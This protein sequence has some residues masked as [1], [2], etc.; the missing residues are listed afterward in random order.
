M[1]QAICPV[2]LFHPLKTSSERVRT[3]ARRCLLLALLISSSYS[4]AEQDNWADAEQAQSAAQLSAEQLR[5]V[6][7]P[8]RK[9]WNLTHYQLDF[10]VD[11]ENKSL[12]GTNVMSY[13]VLSETKAL[14][15][16][17]Q[18]PMVLESA[19]QN[20]EN[21]E[22]EKHGFSYLIS[23][24]Q[25][26]E[27]G[28]EYQ[29]TLAFSGQP[30]EAKNAPWDGGIV[31][32][33]DDNNMPFVA[34]ANQGI[35][36]S[37]W[38]PNKDH[39]YDEP[40]RGIDINIEVPEY[41]MAVANGRLIGV[42]DNLERGSKTYR[43]Q[44]KN[45]I[46][47]YGVNFNLGDYVQF[48]EQYQ[49]ESG[50]LSMD[51]YVLRDNE[52]IAKKQFKD[53]TRT[54]EAFEYWFGPY[55]FYQDGFK[56]VEVPYLGMEHQSSVTYGNGYQNGYKG[57][58][59]SDSGWGMLFDYIII[60]EMGHEWFA[61]NVTASDL[62]D[63]WIQE[64]FT[65][66]SEGL[67]VEY[68]YGKAAGAE[69]LR[70]LRRN[71]SNNKALVGKYNTNQWSTG[72][73]YPKGA[74]LLHTLRQLINNDEKWREILRGLGKAFYHKTVNTQQ[75]EQYISEQTGQDFSLIF[76]QYLRDNRVPIL[77]YYIAGEVKVSGEGTGAGEETIG[78]TQESQTQSSN[79]KVLHIR[80]RNCRDDFTMP[81]KVM[82]NGIEKWLTPTTQFSQIELDQPIES[83]VVDSNFYVVPFNLK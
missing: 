79:T 28:Q 14:Q 52:E 39:A 64:G 25:L 77:E 55:P 54:M 27:I 10:A 45:P 53:A 62:A 44:V 61:N 17:L 65:S 19:Q 42:D 80:Y 50:A 8:E 40:D 1:N 83:V 60:H 33:F 63:I 67:F 11:I 18:P 75:V 70:G 82:V 73:V 16:E 4:S 29:V 41:L 37:V 48:G 78:V 3:V 23:L 13:Q 68:F 20:G 34:N 7:T 74:N 15:I 35:G 58:D 76:E 31:W 5:A 66:Y 81:I 57:R 32:Q 59:L 71:I 49:G 72:D 43:W 56:L 51:Y 38:W 2:S 36:A 6:V 46:N 9:W 22:V 69:Y 30:V 12:S 47:N 24:K 26:Q 21:L